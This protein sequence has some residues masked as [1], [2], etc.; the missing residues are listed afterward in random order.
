YLSF[1]VLIRY[2]YKDGASVTHTNTIHNVCFHSFLAICRFYA[3]LITRVAGNS[4]EII[5]L[6]AYNCD[7]IAVGITSLPY[8]LT[9]PEPVFH[10]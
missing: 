1:S 9:L 7:F 8:V 3:T 10:T 4:T 6:Y 2:D 5:C